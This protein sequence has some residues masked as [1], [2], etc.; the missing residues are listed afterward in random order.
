MK[1][2]IRASPHCFHSAVGRPD[3][4][5]REVKTSYPPKVPVICCHCGAE[6][7]MTG[8]PT[9]CGPHAGYSAKVWMDVG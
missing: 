5:E 4:K 3:G 1:D 7:H 6:T 8:Y 9:T 2:C